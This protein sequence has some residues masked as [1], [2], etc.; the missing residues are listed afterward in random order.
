MVTAL[1]LQ[2]IQCVIKLPSSFTSTENEEE[3]PSTSSSRK[4]QK[5]KS[6]QVRCTTSNV[7]LYTDYVSELHTISDIVK[8]N[9]D[10]LSELH[11]KYHFG[12]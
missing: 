7:K 8:L 9:Q 2:L 1:A 4:G 12:I 3:V 11:T 5:S 6:A 10:N